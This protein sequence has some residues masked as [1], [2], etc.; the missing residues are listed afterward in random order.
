MGE[1]IRLDRFLA[2]M[3]KGSRSQVKEAA[4]KG[5]VRVNGQ[6]ERKTDRKVE[7][8]FDQVLFDGCE[9]RYCTWEYY[10]LNKPQG[11]VSATEDGRH[12]TVVELLGPEG[13]KGL[14]PVGRLD[15]DTEGLLL[16]T[17]DGE[18][19]H[20]LLSPKK[21]VD[22][23][24]YALVS[25]RL[26]RDAM[27]QAAAGMVLADGTK[28]LAAKL[29]ILPGQGRRW[30]GGDGRGGL[31]AKGRTREEGQEE[32]C[33]TEIRLTLQEGKFH[34]VKRMV[35]A[36]GGT[37]VYLKRLSMGPLKLEEG[38]RPG[39]YRRLTQEEVLLL[40]EWTGEG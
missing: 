5:R 1:K 29:E 38:M 39:E 15:I 13:R 33:F 11:V 18:L 22:K 35:E 37:V 10:L 2:D 12:R 14:F 7:P 4:R 19:A 32:P 26:A 30:H 28:L 16:L 8:G 27:E 20:R 23:Q 40:K 17:N 34:Q 21:H 6:V 31:S 24:Y 3:G 9:V 25:G 36:L